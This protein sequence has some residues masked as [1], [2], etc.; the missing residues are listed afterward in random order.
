MSN[1]PDDAPSG[2]SSDEYVSKY[3]EGGSALAIAK[4]RVPSW[5]FLLFA[6][7]A[8]S[9]LG[10]FAAGFAGGTLASILGGALAG[11]F[12][13]A[14]A[15]MMAL[16]FSHLRTVVTERVVHVQ[17]GLFGPKIPIESITSVRAAK[18]DWKRYGGWGIR[19]GR[20]GSICYSVPGGSGDCVE[21]EWTNEKGKKVH[22]VV[23][24]EDAKSL[25]SSIELARGAASATSAAGAT[26]VRVGASA[27]PAAESA[28]VVSAQQSS[29][30]SARRA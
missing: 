27:D 30:E 12:L 1:E 16:L 20:D 19:Y 10:L 21:I 22:H 17:L 6:M 29:N 13:V 11:L 7:P 24:V 8:L 2:G 23:T 14:F 28:D 3:M 25:V 18:Y 9:G 15:A 5:W 4:K 26:G